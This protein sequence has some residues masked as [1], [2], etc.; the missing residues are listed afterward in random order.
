[1]P[2]SLRSNLISVVAPAIRKCPLTTTIKTMEDIRRKRR[3]QLAP[4]I[5]KC[6]KTKPKANTLKARIRKGQKAKKE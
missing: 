2:L 3:P 1:M 6:P 4:K 5:Q